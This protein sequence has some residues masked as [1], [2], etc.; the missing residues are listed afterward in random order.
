MAI[1]LQLASRLISGIQGIEWFTLYLW[2]F[3]HKLLSPESKINVAPDFK[4]KLHLDLL[5][6]KQDATSSHITLSVFS[7]KWY[8]YTECL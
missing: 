5:G 6:A 1:S 2:L 4:R 3:S 7:D 8:I